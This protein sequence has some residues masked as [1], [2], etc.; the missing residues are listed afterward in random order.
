MKAV[1]QKFKIIAPDTG[2][3]LTDP[4]PFNLML[5]TSLG[6]STKVASFLRPETAQGIFV[7]FARL[8]EQNGHKL[9][10]GGA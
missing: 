2:N 7:N 5:A 1:L 8:L 3:E 4:E 9:P 6:P 10:F